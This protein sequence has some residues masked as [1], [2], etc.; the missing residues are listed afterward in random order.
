MQLIIR[1]SINIDTNL[2]SI[3]LLLLFLKP[4]QIAANK[5]PIPAVVVIKD[6][7]KLPCFNISPAIVG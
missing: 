5:A 7:P 1:P 2:V 3:L 6:N 4:I